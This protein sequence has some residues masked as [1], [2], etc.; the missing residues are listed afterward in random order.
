[1]TGRTVEEAVEAALDQL[2]V[3]EVDA[4]IVV[5]EEPKSGMFG[6]DEVVRA[7]G[8]GATD[9]ARAK[10]P[11]RRPRAAS[12]SGEHGSRRQPLVLRAPHASRRESRG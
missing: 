6:S 1:M 3:A 11:S 12:G 4:E 10:R 9:S 5:V 8:T 2:G 7:S